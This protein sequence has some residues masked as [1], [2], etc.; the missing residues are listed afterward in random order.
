MHLFEEHALG[1]L[2]DDRYNEMSAS[3]NSE[4]EKLK[5]DTDEMQKF[6]DE[7][8][9]KTSDIKQ[10]VEIVHKYEHITEITP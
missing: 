2:P 5:S 6:V 3:Y 4:L 1:R 10:F 9:N 8:T 7:H